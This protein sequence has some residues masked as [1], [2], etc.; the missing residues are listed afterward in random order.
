MA[1][2]SLDTL[3]VLTPCPLAS[4]FQEPVSHCKVCGRDVLD[5]STFTREEAA[6][7]LST[8]E[9]PCVRFVMRDGRPMFREA[10]RT[11]VM[12]T[13]LAGA[14]QAGGRAASEP[15]PPGEGLEGAE[16]ADPPLGTGAA[17]EAV[18]DGLR[19]ERFGF[20]G[21]TL[22]PAERRRDAR[23]RRRTHRVRRG[24]GSILR[25]LVVVDEDAVPLLL[26]PLRRR[27]LRRAP[28]HLA[29]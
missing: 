18:G 13:V 24:D 2:R 23:V 16:R 10:L 29:R 4:E 9:P 1:R 7:L 14:A 25:V 15:P 17:G 8:S 22:G 20:D 21:R 28:L 26:P 5:L 6:R 27:Q 19:R 3:R 11:A 12:V